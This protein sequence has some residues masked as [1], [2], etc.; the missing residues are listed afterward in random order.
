MSNLPRGVYGRTTNTEVITCLCCSNRW[1]LETETALGQTEVVEGSYQCPRCGAFEG[2]NGDWMLRLSCPHCQK[3][4]DYRYEPDD[5][6]FVGTCAKCRRWVEV[7]YD[8]V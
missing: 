1:W 7:P 2:V 6:M 4:G 8:D 5:R 3:D